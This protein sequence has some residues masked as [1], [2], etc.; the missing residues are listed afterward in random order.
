MEQN[1]PSLLSSG[2][3]LAEQEISSLE[4]IARVAFVE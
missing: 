4:E 2:L 3:R 1:Y